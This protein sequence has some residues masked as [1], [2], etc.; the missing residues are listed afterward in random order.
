MRR[1]GNG[2]LS[3]LALR[4]G[5]DVHRNVAV[6]LAGF[7][8]LERVRLGI[9][10]AVHRHVK[11]TNLALVEF[12]IRQPRAVSVPEQA[13][14]VPKFLFVHPIGGAV[15][16]GVG[17]SVVCD[18]GLV[19]CGQLGDEN[20][21]FP[22]E[23][24]LVSCWR[25]L[26]KALLAFAEVSDGTGFACRLKVVHVKI[27][28]KR[29]PVES[30][31]GCGENDKALI[32]AE[33]V[34]SK[35][36]AGIAKSLFGGQQSVDNVSTLVRPLHDAR[37]HIVAVFLSGVMLPIGHRPNSPNVFRSKRSGCPDFFVA[38]I[39][40]L[41]EGRATRGREGEHRKPADSSFHKFHGQVKKVV[42]LSGYI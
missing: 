36:L 7:G 18:L 13:L 19:T 21:V 20:V 14:I 32:A 15:D 4:Q 30:F 38:E 28:V 22:H 10:L 6:V 9:E 40:F 37:P 31:V 12:V 29:M 42:C 17:H 16:N 24:H 33:F 3:A 41:A 2:H 26:R 25:Q 1:F 5:V 35:R 39:R 11:F 23:G 27:R 34:P 8:V